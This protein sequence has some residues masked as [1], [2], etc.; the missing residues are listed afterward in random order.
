[1]FLSIKTVAFD[2]DRAALFHSTFYHRADFLI[3]NRIT[4]G[5]MTGQFSEV[6]GYSMP[7]V[8]REEFAFHKCHQ[9]IG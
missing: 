1:M 3:E 5:L 6:R 8:Q 4:N 7:G 2:Q 9:V